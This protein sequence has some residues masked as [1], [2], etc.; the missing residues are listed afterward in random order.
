VV[1]RWLVTGGAGY[2]GAHTA[3]ALRARGDA[4]VVLD[5][6]SAGLAERVDD[7]VA[8]VRA[9]VL[10]GDAVAAAITEHRLDGVMH[11]AAR[12]SVPESVARPLHYWHENVE[13]LRT[14]LAAATGAGVERFVYSSSAAVYGATSGAAVAEDAACAPVNPYGTSKLAGE[15]LLAD[16][17]AATGLRY[18]A[19]R[20]FNVAGAHDARLADR[21]RENL[22]PIA[23][24]AVAAGGAPTVFGTDYDTPDGSCVRD[25]VHVDDLADAHVAATAL[26]DDPDRPCAETLNV[27]VGRGYSV[28]EVLA[29]IA[30]ATGRPV[31]PVRGE[32]RPGDPAAVVAD[33][34]RIRER[35]G[36]TAR[37]DLDD[38]VT[39]AWQART[40]AAA[41]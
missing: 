1:H 18:V 40:A 30:R 6:L 13:G 35:L 11:F 15:W 32:R 36:W 39:S 31:E 41:G 24:D 29:A 7:D 22:V 33:T 9:S 12:K 5:D 27:G 14:V 2:I 38:I 28:L 23:L 8:L 21:G 4:V 37:H 19:L 16:L 25:F 10:D 34:T 20:Y 17:H 3:R 26:L